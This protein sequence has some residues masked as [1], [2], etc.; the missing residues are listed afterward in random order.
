M[1]RI[2][3]SALIIIFGI[4]IISLSFAQGREI[5][6]LRGQ[7]FRLDWAAQTIT[8]RYLQTQG[9]VSYDEVT[10]FAPDASG[11]SKSGKNIGFIDLQIGNQVT[12]EYADTS[13]GPLKLVSMVVL[14]T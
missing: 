5:K 11:I 8:V 4:A 6:S 14:D 10:V 13:P 2:I 3:V 1:K 12:L 9:Y 7:I